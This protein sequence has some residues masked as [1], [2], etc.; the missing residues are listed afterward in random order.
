[1]EMPFLFCESKDCR[2]GNCMDCEDNDDDLCV[3]RCD[4]CEVSFCSEHLL[5]VLVVQNA[6]CCPV[7]FVQQKNN[8]SARNVRLL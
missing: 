8:V 1:M 2:K 5:F 7:V 4:A 6:Y 3:T